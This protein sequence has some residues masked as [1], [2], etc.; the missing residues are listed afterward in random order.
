MS[1]M[2]INQGDFI[3]N[4]C[5]APLISGAFLHFHRNEEEKKEKGEREDVIFCPDYFRQISRSHKMKTSL[6]V[7]F[8]SRTLHCEAPLMLRTLH[9]LRISLELEQYKNDLI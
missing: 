9:K 5:R 1:E 2:Q 8:F 7:R 3:S 6:H 4:C